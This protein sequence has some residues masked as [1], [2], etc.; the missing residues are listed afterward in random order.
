MLLAQWLRLGTFTVLVA[1]V[2]VAGTGSGD[3]SG[4]L[5]LCNIT[6]EDDPDGEPKILGGHW[7]AKD[8]AWAVAGVSTW[9]AI[10]VSC[11][12]IY[13]HLCYYNKP[14]EYVPLLLS[15]AAMKSSLPLVW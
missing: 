9:A 14:E 3:G 8:W 12:A 13:L 10:F 4:E 7:I 5:V 15:A 6:S 11:R 2:L 1:G